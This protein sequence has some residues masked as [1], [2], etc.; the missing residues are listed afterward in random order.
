MLASK[1]RH[2]LEVVLM[3]ASVVDGGPALKQHWFNASRLR[4]SG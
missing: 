2:S 4:A 3:L 1:H